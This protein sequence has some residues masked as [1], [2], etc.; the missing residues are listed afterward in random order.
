VSDII[1]DRAKFSAG[2][3]GGLPETPCGSGST[4]ARTRAQRAWLPGMIERH[5]V[6]SIADIGAGDLNWIQATAIPA[7]VAYTA[8]DLVPRHPRVQPFDLVT[9]V[10]PPVDLIM[11]LWVLNHL[12]YA[13][14][15]Q[16][17]ANL[18]ASG[19]RLLL[20][21]D[22]PRWHHE[23]PPDIHMPHLE[24][25]DLGTDAGDRLLLID[26]AALRA[27]APC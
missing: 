17:I 25:L 13:A 19:A 5:R 9:T 1:G 10:P 11:C 18:R 21:T 20:M 12:P 3:Q 23:Q 16:A 27:A 7:G 6:R 24:T 14:A 4:M 2:W 26:L 15:R 8:Y 22:R